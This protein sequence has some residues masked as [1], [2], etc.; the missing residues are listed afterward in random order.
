MTTVECVL[1]PNPGPYT[2]PG[3]NTYVI[4]SAGEALVLDPGPVI[5]DHLEAIEVALTGLTPVGVVVTHTHPDHAPAANGLG[6][7]LDT[8][9]YGFADGDGFKPTER[10]EDGAIIPFGDDSLVAVH[11][12]GHT[13]DHLCFR[14]ADCLF[15]GDHIMGGSTVIIEDL[16]D[17]MRS[18]HKVADLDPAHLYPGHGPE[19][20]EAREVI[21]G[22]IAHRIEREE[23][24]L[25][26]LAAGAATIGDIVDVVYSGLD[27]TLRPAATLQVHTQL[28]KLNNEGRVSLGLGGAHG[29]TTVELVERPLWPD[30]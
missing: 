14:L 4:E 20:P 10:I 26:A 13:A 11:T 2:G 24:V 8:P 19:L 16:A 12:P 30:N 22:Y 3:T 15:T 6:R 28:T 23:Q 5:V 21:A 27:I 25:Q 9:V 7:E 17:Y 1:A 29:V 18:L